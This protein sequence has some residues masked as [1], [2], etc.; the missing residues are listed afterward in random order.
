MGG[1]TTMIGR[2]APLFGVALGL[3]LVAGGFEVTR[4]PT[5]PVRADQIAPSAAPSPSEA[6]TRT[7]AVA[8]SQTP[9]PTAAPLGQGWRIRIARIGVDLPLKD[10]D[11]ARDIELQKT[12][13]GAAYRLAGS[14]TPGTSGNTYVY[15]HAR[16]AQFLN[17]WYAQLDDIILITGPGAS[18][19]YRVTEIHP[20]VATDDITYLLPTTSERLTLQT[21]SGPNEND[22]RF[23]VIAVPAR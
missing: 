22:P 7:P 14:A 21:S 12:P 3:A 9:Q 11:V 1:A 19:S 18:L 6:Q 17:L 8:A 4:P 13:D 16:W 2:I 23:L 5:A 20:R 10:G 15:G